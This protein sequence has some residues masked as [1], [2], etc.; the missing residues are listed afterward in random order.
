MLALSA[1]IMSGAAFTSAALAQSKE[2]LKFGLA[3]PL[4]GS[5]ALYGADQVKAAQ[6][7]V[8]DINAKGGVNGKQLEMIVVDTQADPQLGI[9]AVKRLTSVDKVP[10]FITAWSSVVKAVAPI[11]NREK[12][13]ELSVGA[14][15]PDIAKLGDYV[16]TTF[17]LAEV[18]VSS[19]AKYTFSTLGKKTAAVMYINNDSGVEGAVI[20]K[21]VFEK[22]GGKVVAYEAYDAK[23]TEFTG[24]LLKVKASNAEIIH[25][26]GLVADL[27]QVIAQMRQLGMQQRVSTYSAGYNPK[28]IEQLGAAAEG[29]I[30][31][32]LAPGVTDNPN[33]GPFIN[34]WKDTE[35]RV[36]N[37]LPYTQYLYDGPY[38]VA[39]LYKWVEKNK[40]SATGEN[41]RKALITAKNFELPMTGGLSVGED[42]RVNKPV[43]LLT[44]D[45]GQFV[46]LATIK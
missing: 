1:L 41:M 38:L 9:N 39:E 12:V 40:L 46:P 29:L 7:A 42:H 25:I 27:P 26:Q 37:G 30:V 8:A 15:S 31:T 11:A 34:R 14:N 28:V 24:A 22:A 43:Y 4:S 21:S 6:W 2:T 18:D 10:V 17:P 44:V 5:Q 13:L 3:M 32:S 23:A 20:Y 33:V 36:P 19:L 16:Y 35:K 45:K